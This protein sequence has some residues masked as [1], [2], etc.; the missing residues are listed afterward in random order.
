M[1]R[2]TIMALTA[3]LMTITSLT[4][5]NA[6]DFPNDCRVA[7]GII[8]LDQPVSVR[9]H[10]QKISFRESRWQPGARN[11]QHAGCMQIATNVHAA[12]IARMGFT[13]DDM[14]RA[15]PNIAVAK[16]LY[17]E[18]GLGPWKATA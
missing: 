1:Y 9:D 2:T 10:M 11:G 5:C 15:G 8:F 3:L 14:F 13:K 17:D 12:R 7:I 18:S 6:R 4:G 16:A